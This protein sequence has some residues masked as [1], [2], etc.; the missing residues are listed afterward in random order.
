MKP[1]LFILGTESVLLQTREEDFSQQGLDNWN[2]KSV[3]NWG[4]NPN[5]KWT[6]YVS[7][8]V[9]RPVKSIRDTLLRALPKL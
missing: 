2:I 5:G 9:S 4:E 3:H 8:N 6:F 1:F 7:A